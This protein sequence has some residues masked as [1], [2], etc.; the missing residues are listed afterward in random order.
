MN[1]INL[2]CDSMMKY[3]FCGNK[4]CI[5][6]L[7]IMLNY[8]L[9]MLISLPIFGGVVLLVGVA[10]KHCPCYKNSKILLNNLHKQEKGGVSCV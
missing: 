5:I 9:S 3:L 7:F 10:C 1:K 4:S 6:G 8:L 2:G